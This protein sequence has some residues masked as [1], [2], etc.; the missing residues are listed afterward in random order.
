[1]RTAIDRLAT[2]ERRVDRLEAQK[3]QPSA[4]QKCGK[5]DAYPRKVTDEAKGAILKAYNEMTE[6]L[7]IPMA[8]GDLVARARKVPG[9]GPA[10]PS[11]VSTHTVLAIIAEHFG[12]AVV[13]SGRPAQKSLE[14]TDDPRI[15]MRQRKPG[16]NG[17]SP[18]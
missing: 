3:P 7:V 17:Q 18:G 15:T 4:P 13:W 1:M 5:A 12:V 9:A 16:T 2:L 6:E 11:S 8:I 14:R 10:V